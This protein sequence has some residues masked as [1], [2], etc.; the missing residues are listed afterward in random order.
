MF[1]SAVLQLVVLKMTDLL[2]NFFLFR[3]YWIDGYAG[4]AGLRGTSAAFS[5]VGGKQLAKALYEHLSYY[6]SF[7]SAKCQRAG[8]QHRKS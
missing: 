6:L 8:S 4:P 5:S 7:I 2:I 3:L 1:C